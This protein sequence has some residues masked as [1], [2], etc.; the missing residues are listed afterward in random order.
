MRRLRVLSVLIGLFAIFGGMLAPAVASTRPARPLTVVI[1]GLDGQRATVRIRG[2]RNYDRTFRISDR[3]QLR[4]LRPGTYRLRA[5]AVGNATAIA[6]SQRVR[7]TRSRAARVVFFYLL[8]DPLTPPTPPTPTIPGPVKDL[9]ATSVTATHI[10]LAWT[11]P[12]RGFRGVRVDRTGGPGQLQVNAAQNGLTDSQLSPD[13]AYTYKVTTFG[14][15]G[16]GPTTSLTVKTLAPG[17]IASGNEATCGQLQ[18]GALSCWGRGPET[19]LGAPSPTAAPVI[20]PLAGQPVSAIAR[21]TSHTCAISNGTVFCWG[22]NTAGQIGNGTSG[23]PVSTPTAVALPG[24]S[25]GADIPAPTRAVAISAG[26]TRT[27]AIADNGMLYCW[28]NYGAGTSLTPRWVPIDVAGMW[29]SAQFV[30]SSG[31]HTCLVTSNNLISC[32]DN[33]A[34]AVVPDSFGLYSGLAV[35]ASH[36]CALSRTGVATCFGDNTLGQLGTGNNSPSDVPVA[37]AGGLTFGAL[38]AG[39]STTCGITTTGA[40]YC[41]GNGVS[42]QLGNGMASSSNT[43]QAV[44]VPAGSVLTAISAA[45]TSC[46]VDNGLRA[47]CWGIGA[48]GQLGNGT[49]PAFS[50]TP[51]QVI[52]VS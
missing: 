41:W 9:R 48:S 31:D 51:V 42:G 8:P 15:A 5:R 24:T 26:A 4:N 11:D 22:A 20:A 40:G 49:S 23:A 35:G 29:R 19:G 6:P 17:L 2:P 38:A 1:Q 30:G 16:D 45:D 3:R 33:S 10:T 12:A 46:A 25:P 47:F 7:V 39:A 18:A 43:P 50:V 52:G 36:A 32:F 28:G 27:C 37:V 13:T 44:Q 14:S 34:P 21:G